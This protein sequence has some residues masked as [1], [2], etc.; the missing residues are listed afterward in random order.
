MSVLLRIS[1]FMF[2]YLCIPVS[3][4]EENNITIDS[5][6]EKREDFQHTLSPNGKYLA[7][8]KRHPNIYTLNITDIEKAEVIYQ[9]N[10][11]KSYP[12]DLRWLSNRRMLFNLGGRVYAVN[13]DGTDSRILI[14]HL[15]DEDKTYRSVS[16]VF[17]QFRTWK[18]EKVDI[19]DEEIL[20]SSLS[21]KDHSSVHKVNVYTGEKT[22]LYDGKKHKINRWILDNNGKV[23][24]AVRTKKDR[25]IFF[26]YDEENEKLVPIKEKGSI[27]FDFSGK[28]YIQN[29]A[30]PVGY[31]HKKD[32]I[33]IIE[34]SGR[35]KFAL[36]S[37]NYRTKSKEMV[38]SDDRYDVGNIDDVPI[39]IYSQKKKKL[40][41]ARYDTDITTTVWFDEE[42]KEIQS[43]LDKRYPEKVN[44]ITQW[45]NNLDLILF[46]SFNEK[47]YGKV[48][49]YHRKEKKVIVQSPAIPGIK[50]SKM[51]SNRAI[52]YSAKDGY[53]IE[54]YL[55]LPPG[56]N[57]NLPLI[58]MPHGGPFA[59][60]FNGFDTNTQVFASH[61]YAVIKPNYRGSTGYGRKHLL[62]GKASIHDIMIDDILASAKWAIDEGIADPEQIHILGFSYGGYASI[63]SALK[64]PDFYRTAISYSAPL[65]LGKQLSWYKKN[66]HHFAYEYWK[67]MVFNQDTSKKYIKSLSPIHRLG[68][69]EIPTLVFHGQNDNIVPNDHALDLKKK[70]KKNKASKVE[71]LILKDEGHSIGL[72]SNKIY[73]AEK[74]LKHFKKSAQKKE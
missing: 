73:F 69:V 16:S 1:C 9:T 51:A 24:L 59:R 20:V 71:V 32:E 60:S 4:G 72:K 42:M 12:R 66:D 38:L 14:N 23:K 2:L 74:A 33:Y 67:E 29:R 61:G 54:A 8:I 63:M 13:H 15:F 6:F 5:Y 36:Y 34:N 26:E 39:L 37:Y 52:Q 47:S 40:I 70:L 11:S 10:I 31:S 68:S 35:D 65:D 22:D 44:Y 21:L 41:G 64:Y 50:E 57:K 25:S 27:N 45:T 58:V 19:G 18:V 43:E 46:S 62:Q 53:S 56:K 7:F 55:T 48:S 17:K 49:I 28:S 30:A 3:N